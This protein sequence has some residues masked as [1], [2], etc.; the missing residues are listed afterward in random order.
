[1]ATYG[2]FPLIAELLTR[3]IFTVL[4]LPLLRQQ[5]AYPV[6]VEQPDH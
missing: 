1:L 4:L 3:L 5:I 2:S 6:F